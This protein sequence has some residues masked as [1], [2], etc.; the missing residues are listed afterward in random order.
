MDRL[1]KLEKF[2]SSLQNLSD[3]LGMDYSTIITKVHP[4]LNTLSCL[5]KNISDA[6]LAKLNSAAESLEEEKNKRL[7]K[8]KLTDAAIFTLPLISNTK[9]LFK[10]Q[11]RKENI[12]W[13]F[14]PYELG[15]N[16][17]S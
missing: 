7:Q 13:K 5:S 9:F 16:L 14:I 15:K 2:L 10:S 1:Q 8:V 12:P 6:I 17:Y 11:Q 4:S 3:T